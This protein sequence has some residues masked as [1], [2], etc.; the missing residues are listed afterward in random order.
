VNLAQLTQAIQDYVE[1]TESLFVSNIP[2]FISQSEMRIAQAVKNPILRRNVTGTL[3]TGNKYL[4]CPFDF[5]A[6]YS[7]AVVD[8]ITGSYSYLLTK[9]VSFMRE[10]YPNPAVLGVPK[11]YSLFGPTLAALTE[12]SFILVPTPDLDYT[13]ELHYFYYPE[14]ITTTLDGTSWLGDNFSPVLLYGALREAAIFMKAEQD[15]VTYYEA[16]YL[17]ALDQYKTLCE[18]FEE[19]D[20]YRAGTLRTPLK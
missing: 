18:G 3:T 16:K 7:L 9:D 13:V 4:S 17:E 19:S 8:P 10:A 5:L 2:V 11:F 20:S 15:M 1:N 12:L 6:S 14:S